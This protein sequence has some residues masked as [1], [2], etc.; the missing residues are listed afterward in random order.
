MGKPLPQ[1]SFPAI[2]N[3]LPAL[4]KLRA[5][6]TPVLLPHLAKALHPALF[7][8]ITK[9]MNSSPLAFSYSPTKAGHQAQSTKGTPLDHLNLMARW[10]SVSGPYRTI[11]MR[12]MVLHRLSTATH[13]EQTKTYPKSA[14]EKGPSTCPGASTWGTGFMLVTYLEMT[15]VLSR[16]TGRKISCMSSPMAWS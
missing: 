3:T 11:K 8:C 7:P 5:Y 13:R 2:S 9:N 14:Y 1:G 10:A 4:P 12:K 15:E 16:T 6:P